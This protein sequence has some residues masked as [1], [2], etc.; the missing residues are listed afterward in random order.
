MAQVNTLIVLVLVAEADIVLPVV[1]YGSCTAEPFTT[2]A[3]GDGVDDAVD[4]F[5]NDPAESVDSDNDGIGNNADTDDDGDG[6]EDSV[7]GDPLDPSVGE[8]P[9]S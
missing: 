1:A 7:D 4:A 2:D 8:L 6:V 9:S 5:P 3:D